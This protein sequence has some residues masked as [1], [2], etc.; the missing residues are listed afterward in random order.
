M[1]DSLD[2]NAEF[3][4]FVCDRKVSVPTDTQRS[5]ITA[6]KQRCLVGASSGFRRSRFRP[7]DEFIQSGPLAG[8]A[9]RRLKGTAK[10]AASIQSP[11]GRLAGQQ[12]R[13]LM[14]DKA[15]ESTFKSLQSPSI[16]VFSTHGY[17]LDAEGQ[18]SLAA[19]IQGNATR[20]VTQKLKQQLAKNPL[21]QCGL[22]LTD[23]NKHTDPASLENDGL[24]TGVEIARA[25]LGGTKLAVLSACETGLGSLQAT[26]G[27][28]G[29]RRAVHVAGAKCVVASL[30]QIPD[31]E[32]AMLME[33]FFT[34][35]GNTKDVYAA[36]QTAQKQI[37]ALKRK[38]TGLAHPF[39][40]AAFG[41]SGDPG[42]LTADA[43]VKVSN[44]EPKDI[45]GALCRRIPM[46][47]LTG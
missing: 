34:E 26:G 9:F 17:F 19:A 16:L 42:F 38:D 3:G 43:A 22:G 25:N 44:G 29:L 45:D 46:P 33:T 13:V 11:I 8:C 32:T 15:L 30:W 39:Y 4:R 35:L 40:W 24:L 31:S 2:G 20:L 12:P 41:I 1:A 21:L 14:R 36:M 37:I 23:A 7:D 47:D 18:L 28:I 5:R 10:E 6:T 27:V